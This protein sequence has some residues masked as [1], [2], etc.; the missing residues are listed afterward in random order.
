[1]VQLVG[2]HEREPDG[3]ELAEAEGA[4]RV[5]RD[6]DLARARVCRSADADVGDHAI[7]AGA[8]RDLRGRAVQPSLGLRD[9]LADDVAQ[10]DLRVPR[11]EQHRRIEVDDES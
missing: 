7:A 11:P 8:D 4:A 10:V 9:R 5:H 6:Q 1:V 3:Q 2:E